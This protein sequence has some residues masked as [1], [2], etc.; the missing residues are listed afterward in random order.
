[1]PAVLSTDEFVAVAEFRASLRS[2]LRKA[3]QTARRVLL[4]GHRCGDDDRGDVRGGLCRTDAV[5]SRDRDADRVAE[6]ELVERVHPLRGADD[7][8]ARGACRV[9]ALPLEPVGE[10]GA[11]EA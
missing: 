2:F 4:D 6:V 1:M 9:A 3:E 5:R 11:D 8:A 10:R 7:Q